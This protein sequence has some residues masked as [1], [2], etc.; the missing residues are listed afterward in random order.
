MLGDRHVTI[1]NGVQARATQDHGE[2]VANRS[3]TRQCPPS[4]HKLDSKKSLS[5]LF[6]MRVCVS[7]SRSINGTGDLLYVVLRILLTTQLLQLS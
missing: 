4:L 1:L 7:P 2:N 5:P 3:L 6:G